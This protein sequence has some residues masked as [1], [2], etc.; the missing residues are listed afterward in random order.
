MAQLKTP[1]IIAG[2]TEIATMTTISNTSMVFLTQEAF[3]ASE[4]ALVTV[5]NSDQGYTFGRWPA[6]LPTATAG[7]SFFVG[8]YTVTANV[9]SLL[10]GDYVAFTVSHTTPTLVPTTVSYSISGT[11]GFSAPDISPTTLSGTATL[12]T[13]IVYQAS[14]DSDTALE[15]FTLTVDSNSSV[16]ATVGIQG[17]VSY[18]QQLY[19]TAGSYTFTVPSDVYFISAVAI[20][21]GGGTSDASAGTRG[22]YT[23]GPVSPFPPTITYPWVPAQSYGGASGGALAYANRIAVTPGEELTVVVGAGA[24]GVDGQSSEIRRGS[25]V[26]LSAAGGKAS[27]SSIGAAANTS[28]FVDSSVLGPFVFYPGGAGGPSIDQPA[29]AHFTPQIPAYNNKAIT[30]GGGGGTGGWTGPGGPSGT[31]GSTGAGGGGAPG[32]SITYTGSWPVIYGGSAG[33]GGRGGGASISDSPQQAGSAGYSTNPAV[34]VTGTNYTSSPDPS[35]PP[36]NTVP[37][38]NYYEGN[39][40]GAGTSP[41]GYEMGYGAGGT[42]GGAFYVYRPPTASYPEGWTVSLSSTG[43]AGGD[44]GIG[45][46]WGNGGTYP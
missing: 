2:N 25:T 20:G 29:S 36:F 44:G 17:A 13:P 10:M 45:I 28:S 26:L 12:G 15:S 43:D 14:S 7:D 11:P 23:M 18:S 6:S 42:V 22:N 30:A 37:A 3:P 31:A 46:R 33:K 32:P 34:S 39:K 38:T 19:D 27:G 9:S 5:A 4:T 1:S 41:G 35:T 40:G 16:T 8:G 21:A 24:K